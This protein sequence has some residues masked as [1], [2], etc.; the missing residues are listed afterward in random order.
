MRWRQ[1]WSWCRA[2]AL[3]ATMLVSLGARAADG[4]AEPPG[5]HE[6]VV[7]I[8]PQAVVIVNERGQPRMYDDPSQQVRPCRSNAGCFG[9]ALG[10][11]AGLSAVTY[12][13]MTVVIEGNGRV[14]GPFGPHD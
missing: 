14:A 11:L 6:R 13:N 7:K 10:V 8:G 4:P 5:E 2:L 12:R 1:W 3:A 9:A